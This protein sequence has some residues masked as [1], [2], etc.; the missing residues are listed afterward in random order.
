[1][2]KAVSVRAFFQDEAMIEA[3][4]EVKGVWKV[5]GNHA[6]AAMRAI[7]DEGLSKA[8]V[9]ERFGAVVGVA[10]VNFAVQA[11]EIFCIMG[12]SGSGKS[13]LV[14]HINRL[15]EP[16]AGEIFIHGKDVNKLNATALRELRGATV[17]MVFQNMALMPHRTV[18]DNVA[19]GLEIRGQTQIERWETAERTL[20]LVNLTGW[21]DRYPRE[22]SGGMQQGLPGRSRPTQKFC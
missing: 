7:R 3:A 10:D 14:R 15:I 9:L 17:A 1:M 11:G 2:M 22:L 6:D 21:E 4:I 5:F 19:L 12:L 13:T 8:A 18:R 20:E 16:T